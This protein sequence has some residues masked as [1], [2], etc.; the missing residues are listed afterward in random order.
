MQDL[1]NIKHVGYAPLVMLMMAQI[2]T[3]G[4]N[5]VMNLITNALIESFGAT[6]NQ[7]QLANIVYSLVT[8]ALMIFGGMLGLAIGWKRNYILGSVLLAV[9]ELSLALAPNMAFLCW[10]SRVLCGLGAALLVPA[11]LGL[12]VVLYQ[13]KDRALAFGSMGAATGLSSILIPPLAGTIISG[14]GWRWAFVALV[15]FFAVQ[16]ALAQ[17]IIPR[18]G[19]GAAGIRLDYRGAALGALGMLCLIYGITQISVWGLFRPIYAPFTLFGLS[20]ALPLALGG[21]ALLVGLFFY[22]KR[23]EQAFGS[24]LVPSSY[25]SVNQVRCGLLLT[26]YLYICFGT[27][28]FLVV[29]WTQLVAGY[30]PTKT[31]LLLIAMAVPMIAFSMGLPKWSYNASPRSICRIGINITALGCLCLWLGVTPDGINDWLIVGLMLLGA[32]QGFVASQS[33]MIIAQAVNARDAAQSGG[34]QAST[35]NV[36]Q[37]LGVAVIGVVLLFSLSGAFKANVEQ[38]TIDLAL[39]QE[40]QQVKAYQL[41]TD[42]DFTALLEKHA[43]SAQDTPHIVSAYRGARLTAIRHAIAALFVVV[44]LHLLGLGGVPF[45]PFTQNE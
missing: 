38:L 22:E 34:I 25:T 19:K 33:S 45:K 32:G 3:C 43:L 11:I 5:T 15:V 20:P 44:V 9:G 1:K 14:A 28:G 42:K 24:C 17:V 37:A 12:C 41:L 10:V 18:D 29:T 39:K 7:V 35:R 27:A 26:S 16:A 21:V 8:G 13:G 4:D 31:G 30:S 6:M 2:G 36:G 40:A 23:V